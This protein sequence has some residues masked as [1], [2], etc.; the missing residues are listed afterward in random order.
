MLGSFTAQHTAVWCLLAP[1]HLPCCPVLP[2]GLLDRSRS[3]LKPSEIPS[4]I[5]LTQKEGGPS[6]TQGPFS[7]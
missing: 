1:P 6:K 7:L 3:F 5:A 4:E 2:L